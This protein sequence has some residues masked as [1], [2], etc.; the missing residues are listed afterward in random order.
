[1]STFPRLDAYE[2]HE[3]GWD[4]YEEFCEAFEWVVPERFNIAHYVCDTWADDK[5]KVALFDAG[6]G[7][8]RSAHTFWELREC[9]GRLASYLS[10]RGIGDGDRICVSGTQGFETAVGHL[11]AW[12]LGAISVP[13][14][15]L[16]GTDGLGYRLEDSGARA[17]I[18]TEDSVDTLRAVA[19]RADDL[20]TVVV[21]RDV[22]ARG[23]EIAFDD[24]LAAA[25]GPRD[26]AQTSSDDDAVMIYTSGTTGQPKGVVHTHSTLLGV[27]P[28]INLG[29]FNLSVTPAD[30]GRTIV[31]W[32]WAGA[33]LDFVLP[34]WYYGR[35]V[36]AADY[37]TFD[38]KLE[39]ELVQR[40]GIT[41]YHAPPTGLRMMMQVDGLDRYSLDSVRVVFSGGESVGDSIV[42]WAA[43]TF[44][45]AVVHEGYG[46]T[47]APAFVGDCVALGVEHRAGKMGKPS[48]GS[49]VAVFDAE[50]R[51]SSVEPGEIGELALEY[52]GNP[53]CFD[54]YWNRPEKTAEKV[55][56]GWLLSEDLVTQDV[57]GYVS[58]GSR[59]DDVIISSGYRIGPEEIEDAIASHDRVVDAGVIGV[60]DDERGE[61]VKAFVVLGDGVEADEQLEA[62]LQ[63]WVR[64]RLAAYEYPRELEFVDELPTTETGKIRRRDLRDRDGL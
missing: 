64:D 23:D 17:F 32:S 12:K 4:T 62:E 49:R 29:A 28:C 22:T 26:T 34:S 54:R 18:A 43:E 13:L 59:T 52:E 63:A 15:V 36:V 27:L 47:E 53:G 51:S 39:L 1:M 8:G 7:T 41:S 48:P 55:R 37:G 57:D 21:A 44:T 2:F 35:P 24:A 10:A 42:E 20:E 16:L 58:F 30:V 9:A 61:I 14:S 3:Q 5:S 25:D 38:P 56:N 46:Q 11:A 33:L 45:G 6:D 19:E 60:P 50:T 31:E 40:Y